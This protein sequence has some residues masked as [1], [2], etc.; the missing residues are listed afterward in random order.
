MTTEPSGATVCPGTKP[1]RRPG[2]FRLPGGKERSLG[3]GEKREA[4]KRGTEG[5]PSPNLTSSPLTPRARP[6]PTQGGRATPH[7]VFKPPRRDALGTWKGGRASVRAGRAGEHP[8]PPPGRLNP[9]RSPH[10]SRVRRQ[11]SSRPAALPA[12]DGGRSPADPGGTGTTPS[13][14]QHH[15][16]LLPSRPTKPPSRPKTSG[17]PTG[18]P[19][20]ATRRDTATA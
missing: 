6:P 19:P 15:H 12:R 11:Q 18:E 5:P 2:G 13:C 10:L 8:F 1:H 9:Q 16:H 4:R 20:T 14:P 7:G 17:G 3:R